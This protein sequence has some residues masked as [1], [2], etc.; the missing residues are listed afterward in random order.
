MDPQTGQSGR[1][2]T[3]DQIAPGTYVQF[4]N[5]SIAAYGALYF[6]TKP[7]QYRV[8]DPSNMQMGT[9]EEHAGMRFCIDA[10]RTALPTDSNGKPYCPYP[11]NDGYTT[12]QFSVWG[13]TEATNEG[14]DPSLV[15]SWNTWNNVMWP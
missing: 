2:R 12:E 6:G 1:F 9:A 5:A 7:G 10:S 4:L 13:V 3:L 14:A 8:C 15:Q 11:A